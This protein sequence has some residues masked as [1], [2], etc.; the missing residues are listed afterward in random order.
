M[1]DF[2][3]RFPVAELGEVSKSL[4]YCYLITRMTRVEVNLHNEVENEDKKKR[5]KR[6]NIDLVLK[7]TLVKCMLSLKR[8]SLKTFALKSLSRSANAWETCVD[9]DLMKGMPF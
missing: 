2:S 3:P 6:M 4:K 8:S 5:K 1:H 7:N 9:L